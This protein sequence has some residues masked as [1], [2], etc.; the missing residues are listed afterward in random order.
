MPKPVMKKSD[1]IQ[2]GHDEI[3]AEKQEFLDLMRDLDGDHM[4]HC[5]DY[6]YEDMFF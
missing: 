3:E 5:T 6:W 2:E 1:A 4:W